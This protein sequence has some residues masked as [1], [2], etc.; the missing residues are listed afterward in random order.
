MRFSIV[1]RN[2]G[3]K[4]KKKSLEDTKFKIKFTLQRDFIDFG[5]DL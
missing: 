5:L 2:R 1:C 4:K 3:K